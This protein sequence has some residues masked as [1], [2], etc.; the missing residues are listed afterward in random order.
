MKN[1]IKIPNVII[2]LFAIM[3]TNCNKEK[4]NTKPFDNLLILPSI[5]AKIDNYLFKSEYVTIGNGSDN[6]YLSGK[7]SLYGI[8]I[9]F[10]TNCG[11]K[12]YI[13]P[14]PNENISLGFFAQDCTE[15][16]LTITKYDVNWVEGSFEFKT[17]NSQFITNGKFAFI[18]PISG[19]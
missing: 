14:N 2:L 6:I 11:K 13:F 12:T 17:S 10:P 4:I 5:T 19:N 7:D 1:E 8:V 16:K 15:G 9:R 3:F 18:Y